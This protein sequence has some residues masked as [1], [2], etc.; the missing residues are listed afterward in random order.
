MNGDEVLYNTLGHA[1]SVQDLVYKIL[2]AWHSDSGLGTEDTIV[3]SVP[4]KLTDFIPLP[5]IDKKLIE[6]IKGGYCNVVLILSGLGGLGKTALAKVLMALVCKHSSFHF[7]NRVDRLRDIFFIPGQGLVLDEVCLADRPVDDTKA[8]LDLEEA[9]DIT[10][11]NKDG[12]I[13]KG[14]PRI[15]CTNWCWERFWPHEAFLPEHEGG[16]A[17]RF[18]WVDVACVCLGSLC[19][20][21]GR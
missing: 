7:I 10:C 12:R 5:K 2:A 15:I 1:R 8:L 20:A 11:R 6:W 13:P 14:C 3:T 4:W 21:H 16:V 18:W 9:R 19:R 17:R